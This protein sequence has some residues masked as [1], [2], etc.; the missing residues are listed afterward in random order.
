[1]TKSTA[2]LLE[3]LESPKPRPTYE[4]IVEAVPSTLSIESGRFWIVS[5]RKVG[6]EVVGRYQV[7]GQWRHEE[8]YA[9]LHHIQ[10]SGWQLKEGDVWQVRPYCDDEIEFICEQL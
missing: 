8:M 7:P 4:L 9:L 10:R 3:L 5:V 1:M 2:P 6:A